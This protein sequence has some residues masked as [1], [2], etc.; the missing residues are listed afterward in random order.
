M[1]EKSI[2]IM[3]AISK[4]MDELG[5]EMGTPKIKNKI[6]E[7]LEGLYDRKDIDRVL[8]YYWLT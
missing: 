1:D 4:T 5:I 2:I 3:K 8:R 6:Y 7:K